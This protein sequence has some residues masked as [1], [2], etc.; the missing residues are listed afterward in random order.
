MAL[1]NPA[2]RAVMRRLEH[3]LPPLA[4]VKEPVGVRRVISHDWGREGTTVL[5]HRFLAGSLA[6]ELWRIYADGRVSAH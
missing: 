3:G 1:P 4:A 5:F 2:Q 6:P